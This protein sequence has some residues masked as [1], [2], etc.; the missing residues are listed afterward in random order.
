MPG[1]V[2]KTANG[3]LAD[4][5]VDGVRKTGL[6]KTK[7]EATARKRELL[8]ALLQR[9]AS[10]LPE[11]TAFSLKEARQ[12]SLTV[13]WAGTSGE[14]T[15]IMNSKA[16][17]DHFGER[18]LVSEITTQ[19]VDEWRQV[20]LAKGNRPST[21]N[22]KV[23]AL[24]S[25]L[26]D[27]QLRGHLSAMPGIPQQ[28]KENNH[29]DRVITED[30][31]ALFCQYFVAVGEP[32]ACDVLHL[33]LDSCARWGEIERLKGQDVDLA[34]R[35]VTFWKTKNNQ[36][37]SIGLT[38]RA[39]EIL[40]RRLPAVRTHRVFT[41]RYWQF[42]RLFNAAKASM[43]LADDEELTI[44]CTRHTCASKMASSGIPLQKL[45]QFGGWSSLAAV[46]RYLHLNTDALADCVA[47]L[48]G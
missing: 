26:S 40:E 5:S 34:K 17:L 24:R 7:A 37:R 23:S 33:L 8:E 42:E 45:M 30:E 18:C 6:C 43:G 29:R 39:V 46:Q 12:L 44:H 35:R 13:R 3:W 36:P 21:V 20:L 32:E 15:A 1:T 11:P 38:R 14:R 2:R 27:A 28:L 41:Y 47:A 48:E 9:T 22:K 19:K 25:M 10:P 31:Q 4:V 16:A